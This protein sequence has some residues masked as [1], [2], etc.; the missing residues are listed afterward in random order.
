[1][2]RRQATTVHP[3]WWRSLAIGISLGMLPISSFA[4]QGSLEGIWK[5]MLVL[6]K[7]EVEADILVEI[8]RAPDGTLAGT[9][10]MPV[11]NYIY[12]PFET[13]QLDG[14]EATLEFRRD[15]ERRG[16]NAL[17]IFKGELS[18]DGQK[19]TGEVVDGDKTIPFHLTWTD[20]PGM[21]REEP[22]VPE[23][24]TMS[25]RGDELRE[26][27]NRNKDHVRLVLTLSPT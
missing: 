12:H 7:A 26:A 20:P 1:M 22:W 14:S 24:T 6:K 5:G 13:I 27:F 16:K 3:R 23:V 21:P 15:S 19:L 2:G 4:A 10:D 17:F 18:E 11:Q 8:G 9:F 25:D